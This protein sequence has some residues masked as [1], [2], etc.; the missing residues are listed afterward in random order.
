[1]IQSNKNLKFLARNLRKNMTD[2]EKLVWSNVR[3]KQ[4]LGYQFYRQKVIGNY[5]V[6]FYCPKAKLAIEIDGGQH[7]CENGLKKDKLRDKDLTCLGIRVIR[8]SNLDILKNI[9]NVM[10]HI[11]NN[12]ESP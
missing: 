6:N 2:A 3:R 5:I 9:D 8:F 7:Y 1:M 11:Y 12:M 4:V 10:E